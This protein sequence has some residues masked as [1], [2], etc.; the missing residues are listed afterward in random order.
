MR[1]EPDPTDDPFEPYRWAI[2]RSAFRAVSDQLPDDDPLK[3]PLC[4][5]VYRLTEMRINRA[6]L[7]HVEVVRRFD[8]H[9]IDRPE[10]TR[11]PLAEILARA[12]SDGA[13]RA[14][15]LDSYVAESGQLASATDLLWQRRREVAARMGLDDPLALSRP[16]DGG[17]LTETA[18]DFLAASDDACQTYR[19]ER[20]ADHLHLA[21]GLEADAGWP[22]HLTLRNLIGPLAST[23]LFRSLDIDPGAFP[24]PL[25]AASYLRGLRRLGAAWADAAA[26]RDQPF[27]V[28]RDPYGLARLSAGA[29]FACLPLIRP[30]AERELGLGGQA[31]DRHRRA[32]SRVVLLEARALGMRAS[33]LPV[34]YDGG[35]RLREA[36]EQQT[37]RW[38]GLRLPASAAGTLFRAR[39]DDAQRFVAIFAAADRARRLRDAHDEDWYR[40][41][42]AVE[43]LR[44]EAALPPEHT[45]RRATID[46][47][48]RVLLEELGPWLG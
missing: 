5:W 30:F 27:V 42:R 17:E 13:R 15:W 25:S 7:C 10:H 34:A 2:G 32:L 12:L 18:T 44:A 38:L 31:L 47:G 14:A 11:L 26:P 3:L 20:L 46:R 19:R 33:L 28:A 36:F 9:V 21:L 48:A 45:M 8:E 43:Q 41:P 40:N 16:I 24:P 23:D 29:L 1:R 6:A 35:E 37:T 39:V 4:R 22:A